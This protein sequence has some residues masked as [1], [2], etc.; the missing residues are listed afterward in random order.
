MKEQLES[1]NALTINFGGG[2]MA[3]VNVI[4]AFVMFG[5]ALGIKLQTFKDVFKNPKSVIVG[6]L[7]QWVGLPAVT[8]LATMILS[9]LITPMVA[10]G[11]ILVACCP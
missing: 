5:V 6:V 8:F 2:G 9:P 4:L 3:I 1:L 10:L 11:M 7:L